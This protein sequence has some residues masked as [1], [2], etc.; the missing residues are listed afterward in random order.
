MITINMFFKFV[1]IFSSVQRIPLGV[2]FLFLLPIVCWLPCNALQSVKI[3]FN[4]HAW[5]FVVATDIMV[6][7]VCF[8]DDTAR[9]YYTK[10]YFQVWTF[11]HRFLLSLLL[12]NI[13]V[14]Y[15]MMVRG[16]FF[17]FFN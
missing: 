16:K 4:K 12:I 9:R 17:E 3:I 2:G 11:F 10:R 7:I 14:I 8:Y 6:T 1:L 13:P 15:V 5:L